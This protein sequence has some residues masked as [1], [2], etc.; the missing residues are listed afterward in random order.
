MKHD[1]KSVDKLLRSL[2]PPEFRNEEHQARLLRELASSEE[3]RAS[4]PRQKTDRLEKLMNNL[5][6]GRAARWAVAAA[7]VVL[8]AAIFWGVGGDR[9]GRALAQAIQKLREATKMTCIL[10]V[11]DKSGMDT[12]IK[13]QFK[14]PSIIRE[15]QKDGVVTVVDLNSGKQIV[16]MEK[17]K[18]YFEMGLVGAITS[19]SLKTENML[20]ELRQLPLVADKQLGSKRIGE[21]DALGF[22]QSANGLEID[23]WVNPVTQTPVLIEYTPKDNPNVRIAMTDIV[24][25][26]PVDDALFSLKPPA[27]YTVAG[28]PETDKQPSDEDLVAFFGF[29]AKY[30]KTHQFPDSLNIMSLSAQM[31]SI[32]ATAHDELKAVPLEERVKFGQQLKRGLMFALGL[33]MDQRIEWKYVGKGCSLKDGATPILWYRLWQEKQYH[34]ITADLQVKLL[35][36]KD[37]PV[38]AAYHDASVQI[39]E[40]TESRAGYWQ[41]KNLAMAKGHT[42]ESLAG[43]AYADQE[44]FLDIRLPK[45][46]KRYD[47]RVEIERGGPNQLRAHLRRALEA[48]FGLRTHTETRMTD[49]YVLIAPQGRPATLRDPKNK[50]MSTVDGTGTKY[51]RMNLSGLTG[52]LGNALGKRVLNETGLKGEYDYEFTPGYAKTPEA[53]AAAV[54]SQLK[55]ELVPARRELKFLVIE[56]GTKQ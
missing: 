20:A 54:R 44:D 42:L 40:S 16:L 22:R 14:A 27:G 38:V 7:S 9:S 21:I 35:D 45:D 4:R 11:Q 17:E 3:S 46:G 12:Q 50:A 1:A 13:M 53:L 47:A 36:A 56:M 39:N 18:K 48:K 31:Q 32:G 33:T 41:E 52:S 2:Q 43:L 8:V 5:K 55:L 24:F 15:V 19:Q 34:I 25:D 26:P 28:P 23:T 37:F 51:G 6:Q 29:F 10:H 30:S 49:V